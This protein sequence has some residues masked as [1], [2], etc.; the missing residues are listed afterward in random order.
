[1][2]KSL[3]DWIKIYEAK[4]KEKFVRDESYELF[5]LPEKGFCKIAVTEKMILVNQVCGDGIFWRNFANEIAKRLGLKIGKV[6]FVRKNPKA[7]IRLLGYKILEEKE[8]PQGT[9]DFIC[10]NDAGKKATVTRAFEKDLKNYYRVY[11]EV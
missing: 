5:Y 11:W 4:A 10:V 1:M 6:Y 2:N 9:K 3:E 8:N 7:Y